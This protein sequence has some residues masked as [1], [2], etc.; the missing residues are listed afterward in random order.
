MDF[1]SDPRRWMSLKL[2][3]VTYCSSTKPANWEPPVS[4]LF[5]FMKPPNIWPASLFAYAV[6]VMICCCFKSNNFCSSSTSIF[7]LCGSHHNCCPPKPVLGARLVGVIAHNRSVLVWAEC[8]SAFSDWTRGRG[9]SCTSGASCHGSN[10]PPTHPG[11]LLEQRDK[12]EAVNVYLE[13]TMT[14]N[15]NR[16]AGP[17]RPETEIEEL[18][19]HA[20]ENH[21]KRWCFQQCTRSLLIR[22]D[23]PCRSLHT[24]QSRSSTDPITHRQDSTT[25][26]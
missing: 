4:N 22:A 14:L 7:W 3:N 9:H 24:H 18:F 19:P 2:I 16:K 21:P 26:R 8:S 15:K 25:S 5:F 10:Q 11:P 17:L 6:I 20:I 12:S 23:L 1:V 13:R